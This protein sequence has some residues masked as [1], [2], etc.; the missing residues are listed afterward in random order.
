MIIGDLKAGRHDCPRR[1]ETPFANPGVAHHGRMHTNQR[2]ITDRLAMDDGVVP[3]GDPATDFIGVMGITVDC[4][5]VLDIRPLAE[6]DCGDI[7]PDHRSKPHA[8]IVTQPD[9][10]G[11]T[12]CICDP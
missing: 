4:R 12:G 10:A 1:D 3:D 5:V 8:D 9:F 6:P 11:D 7:S 2:A